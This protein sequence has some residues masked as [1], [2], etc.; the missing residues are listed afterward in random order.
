LRRNHFLRVQ[1]ENRR[2]LILFLLHLPLPHTPASTARAGSPLHV[3]RRDPARRSP[4]RAVEDSGTMG[5]HHRWPR[6]RMHC[7]FSPSPSFFTRPMRRGSL[8]RRCR[9]GPT[10]YAGIKSSSGGDVLGGCRAPRRYSHISPLTAA[11]APSPRGSVAQGMLTSNRASVAA[12]RLPAPTR[13]PPPLT[14]PPPF[15]SFL[16][17]VATSTPSASRARL[18]VSP[19][20][21]WSHAVSPP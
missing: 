3:P 13:P 1:Y 6:S 4:I 19:L 18:A 17:V 7:S 11:R 9:G 2:N 8:A 15:R 21:H 10:L 12:R 14:P 16:P 20:L 5:M